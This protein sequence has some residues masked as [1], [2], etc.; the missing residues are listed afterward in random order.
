METSQDPAL[1]AERTATRDHLPLQLRTFAVMGQV[2]EKP[3]QAQREA[4]RDLPQTLRRGSHSKLCSVGRAGAGTAGSESHSS[5]LG[6]ASQG[7]SVVH[8]WQSDR[9]YPAGALRA[10]SPFRSNQEQRWGW[11]EEPCQEA[12]EIAFRGWQGVVL[13]EGRN[14]PM[15]C[16]S[17]ACQTQGFLRY[18][19]AGPVLMR[20]LPRHSLSLLSCPPLISRSIKSWALLGGQQGPAGHGQHLGSNSTSLWHASQLQA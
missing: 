13:A 4:G 1:L 20:F 3:S 18:R 9:P 15:G 8:M 17:S 14:T 16:C 2:T 19:G 10:S 5:P 12:S 6:L 11:Q 7:L